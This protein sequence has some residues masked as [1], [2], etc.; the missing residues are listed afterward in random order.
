MFN[1]QGV[2]A[3]SSHLWQEYVPLYYV[4]GASARVRQHTFALSAHLMWIITFTRLSHSQHTTVSTPLSAQCHNFRLITTPIQTTWQE[5]VPLEHVQGINTQGVSA[6]TLSA[7]LLLI[8]M[9]RRL[10]YWSVA[11]WTG[12]WFGGLKHNVY[13]E[14]F[15]FYFSAN[16]PGR[17]WIS[18]SCP[19]LPRSR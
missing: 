11:W 10:S 5:H 3:L 12:Q 6:L 7:H 14:S 1:T 15:I 17:E 13:Q 9:F 16:L 4:Q 18:A 2:S 19:P 8:I